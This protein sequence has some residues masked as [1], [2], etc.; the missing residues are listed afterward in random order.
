MLDAA[1]QST[2]WVMVRLRLAARITIKAIERQNHQIGLQQITI[3][4]GGAE[5]ERLS[6]LPYEIMSLISRAGTGESQGV[7]RKYETKPARTS[8]GA[9]LLRIPSTA[10]MTEQSKSI[11]TRCLRRG[12]TSWACAG[13]SEEYLEGNP[14]CNGERHIDSLPITNSCR[15]QQ[16]PWFNGAPV[17]A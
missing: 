15:W 6:Q 17:L 12:D 16:A 10:S 11:E 2:V 14:G 9:A 1:E 5:L 8:D 4:A 13:R 7:C 3:Y